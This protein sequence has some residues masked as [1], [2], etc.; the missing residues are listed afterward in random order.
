MR[1]LCLLM[2]F[3]AIGCRRDTCEK[4]VDE[5]KAV[6]DRSPIV[7]PKDPKTIVISL[8]YQNMWQNWGGKRRLNTD[9]FLMIQADGSVTAHEQFGTGKTTTSKITPEELHELLQFAIQDNNF[10]A[11][12]A[13]KVKASIEAQTPDKI[14]DATATIIRIK[15]AEK[16]HEAS[17]YAVDHFV[18]WSKELR[19]FEAVQRRLDQLLNKVNAD[20][21]TAMKNSLKLANEQLERQFLQGQFAELPVLSKDDVQAINLKENDRSY[22][23]FFRKSKDILVEVETPMKGEPKVIVTVSPNPAPK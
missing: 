1:T 13:D 17:Y 9:P 21:E 12:D 5:P 22:V 4:Q 8:D 19:K 11:F 3:C 23:S 7:L 18:K 2:L 10:F 16:E 15:T 20:G 14:F 6:K